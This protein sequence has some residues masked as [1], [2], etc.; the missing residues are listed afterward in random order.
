[1]NDRWHLVFARLTIFTFA[2]AIMICMSLP[3]PA[4]GQGYIK[5]DSF[6]ETM[7]GSRA[8]LKASAAGEEQDKLYQKIRL[9]IMGDFPVESDW[10]L[11]DNGNNLRKWFDAGDDARL[12]MKMIA[13]V[14]AEI[15]SKGAKLESAFENLKQKKAAANDKQW[16]DL[17]LKACQMRRAAR[18]ARLIETGQRIVFTKHFNMGGSHYAYTEA[19][20]DAQAE[21]QYKPG[22]SLCILEMDGLYGTVETLIDD[23]KG[24]IRDPGVS[25]DGKTILFSWKKSDREDDYHLYEMDA[26]TRKITQITS[27][28]GFADYE[29]EYLPNDDI[30]FNSTRC[31]QIVDCWWTEVSNLYTCDRD[32]RFLRRLTFD[33]V[34]TNFPTIL[35]D[36]TVI[37]TRWD[38]NDRG[39]LFPQPLFQMNPDGTA[40]REFYGNNSWFP[41]TIL[42]ARGIP[43]TNKVLAIATG[44]HSRQTG[45]L[46]I[47]DPA[48]GRQENSGIQ[49]IAPVRETKAER[50]DAY[51]QKGE[52]FQYPCPLSETEYLVTYSP[53]GWAQKPTLFNIYFMDIDGRREL[54]AADPKISCNQ[55]IP[56]IPRPRPH[57]RPQLAD[58]RKNTGTYYVQDI[59]AGQSLKDVPRGTINKL[60]VVEIRFRAAGVRSN[61]NRGPAGGALVSTPISIDNGTWDVK[62][63]LGDAR[64]Y[65]DGSACFSVPA[66]TPVYFQA[67]DAKG[68][69]VQSMRTWSTLQPGE[70]FSCVG[71][72]ETKNETPAATRKPTIAMRLGPQQLDRFYGPARGFS[73][74]R[75]IQP[76]LDRH[77]IRCHNDRTKNKSPRTKEKPR[78]TIDLKAA[79][80]IFGRQS[81][82]HYTL[83]DPGKRWQKTD[84]D[85]SSWE[86]GQGGFGNPGTPGAKVKTRWH[87]KDIWLRRTFDLKYDVS[88]RKLAFDLHHDEDIQIYIN[89]IRVAKETG[90]LKDYEQVM[91]TDQALKALKTGTNVIAVHCSQTGG[92]QYID[93]G[94]L[95]VVVAK[96]AGE[97]IVAQTTP[98]IPGAFSLL[99]AHNRDEKAGRAWSDAYLALTNGGDPSNGVV[100]WLNA[101]SIPPLLPPYYAGSVKSPLIEML[102]DGHNDVKLS[103]EEMDKIACW[104]DLLVPYCGDYMED[105][106]WNEDELNKYLH[107]QAKRDMMAVAEAQNI[108]QLISPAKPAPGLLPSGE[109]I[110]NPYRN[111]ALNPR[112]VQGYA[113]SWPHASSN[114]E[115]H[116]MPAFAA[117]NT[118]NGRTENTGHGGKFPSWGPHK[119]KGLW[120]KVDFG[121]LVEIDKVTLYIR[122]DFPHDDYWHSA[123]IEFSDGTKESIII[124][125]TTGPQEFKFAKRIVSSLRFTDLVEAEPLGWCGFTEVQVWGRDVY[126]PASPVAALYAP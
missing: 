111:V 107:F 93:L 113:R 27:G 5:K 85:I 29:A 125:K 73:F 92:G 45:K 24:V 41:T 33:Q 4:E 104:I 21:R 50:I 91:L 103:Q 84:F 70:T 52:L 42:H 80:T 28:L 109:E 64:V 78:P 51:G 38:Y 11:Q 49:L 2:L 16:L 122:A 112:D 47:I 3:V 26:E 99:D 67:L 57:L 121:R 17:Y 25:Y 54:L 13:G 81:E 98:N 97:T 75:E 9:Q 66:R 12:E 119:L 37:Y 106:C 86:K 90:H 43:G 68:Y 120:W 15:G 116:N 60:R 83:A 123:T 62:V 59:Y 30:I 14:L 115:Y 8:A 63:V 69:V 118:I 76:I 22:T 124:R 87:T 20:S 44:H 108:R 77:C 23:P 96:G 7:L 34:H 58:Y 110:R 117:R 105:N 94:L 82:W 126:T 10:M 19:Q 40:Q 39:Q 71:C 46:I 101:Q 1:M 35:A 79:R 72:H 102:E 53:F 114:S 74:N 56:L 48:K 55:P 65:E 18:L 88:S 32:G 61:R 6:S 100:R 31:V 95:D 89:G 36:G